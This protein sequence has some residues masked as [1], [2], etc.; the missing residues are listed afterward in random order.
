MYIYIYVYVYACMYV[1]V[2]AR[3]RA[4]ACTCVCCV[5]VYAWDGAHASR[6][7]VGQGVT[8]GATSSSLPSSTYSSDSLTAKRT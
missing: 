6:A 8:G 4:R 7:S 2:Y 3:A 1:C 5:R